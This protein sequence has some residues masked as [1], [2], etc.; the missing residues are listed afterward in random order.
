MNCEPTTS[1]QGY[2]W[3]PL[4][5][6]TVAFV[7]LNGMKWSE[8]YHEEGRIAGMA[9]IFVVLAILIALASFAGAAV[10]LEK[11]LSAD[12]GYKWSGISCFVG[13]M[14]LM[15]SAFGMR[16]GTLPPADI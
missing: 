8:L 3:L 15:L 12:T 13:T 16:F 6:V 1:T 14:L 11:M 2:A 5:G 10:I 9:R 4:A 7:M